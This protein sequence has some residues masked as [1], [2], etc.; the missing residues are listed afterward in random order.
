ML[1]NIHLFHILQIML[2]NIIVTLFLVINTL[3][4]F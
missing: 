2:D 1:Q 4:I 3:V